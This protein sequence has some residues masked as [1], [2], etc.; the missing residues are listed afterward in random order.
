M[1]GTPL[2]RVLVVEDNQELAAVL[3]ELLTRHG[4]EVVIARNGMEALIPLSGP[5]T[6]RPHLV[7]LDVNL[8]L[9]SGVSVLDFVRNALQ[10]KLPVVVL[11]ASANP[12]Q[13]AE[14][15]RL[16]VSDFLRKPAPAQ[17][18]LAAVT[19]ALGRRP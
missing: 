16:G 17:Q 3:Q 15:R 11:T 4:Y 19:S 6:E 13:E 10:S 12:A 7:L 9:Q 5:V 2:S 8:P 18:V 14:L 1:G